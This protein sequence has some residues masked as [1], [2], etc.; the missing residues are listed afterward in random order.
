MAAVT[1]AAEIRVIFVEADGAAA[2]LGKL[3]RAA[4]QD[5]FARAVVRHQFLQRAAFR[6]AVFRV[7]VVVVKPRAVA[8]HQVALDLHE[9]QFPRGV[10]REIMRLVVVLPQFLDVES[11]HVGVRILALIIPPHEHARFGGAAHQGDGFGHHVQVFLRIARDADLRLD[12][13]LDDRGDVAGG[14]H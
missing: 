8:Q 12:A 13:E 1:V 2:F 10:L 4:H 6:R 7:G 14:C 3:S 9:T 5:A 11:A